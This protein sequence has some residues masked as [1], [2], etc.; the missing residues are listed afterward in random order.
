M[1]IDELTRRRARIESR[2]RAAERAAGAAAEIRKQLKKQFGIE[3]AD[4]A[5]RLLEQLRAEDAAATKRAERELRKFEERYA[6]K[7]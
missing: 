2:V 4:D 3:T 6:R 5:A 7:I 1:N